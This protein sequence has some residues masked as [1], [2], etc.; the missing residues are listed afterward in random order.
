[1]PSTVDVFVNG[2]R[3]ASEDVPPGPFTID[4][5]PAITG[6][7]QMQV[8]VTDALGRQQVIAQ[9]YYSG[10][11]L[12]RAGPQRVLVRGGRDPRGLRPAQQRLR[13]PGRGR[14]V[15]AR[16]HRP[17]SPPRCTPRRR[18]A[19]QLRPAPTRPGRS[20]N[21][22][23]RERSPPRPAATKTWA[24]SAASASS[25]TATASACSRARPYATE[26]FAQLGTDSLEDRP[27]QRSFGGAGLR[28][29]PLRQPA[30]RLR[31]AEQLDDA[32]QR[33]DRLSHSVHARRLGYLNFIASHSTSD[34]SATDLFLSWTL[35]LGDRRTA[36][37]STAAVARRDRRRGLRGGRHAAAEPAGGQRHRLLR[38][39]VLERGRAA[40]LPCRATPASSACSTRAATARTAGASTRSGGL[41]IT[42]AGV[43]PSRRLDQSFA[44]VEVADFPD[45][46]VF[47]ENQPVGRTDKQGPRAARLAARLRA[48]RR[49]HR[50]HGTADG[51]LAGDAPP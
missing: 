3:V 13:R 15:P 11:T 50:P 17:R 22:R 40:R 10:R 20:G 39:A 33:D 31:P 44:V 28:P 38:V 6:A 12:L 19:A 36:A 8:V 51:R 43:M 41:A 32:E 30:A 9:P 37:V 48:Q 21:A 16:L 5:L 42:G 47:V 45:M 46:T 35:P 25:A 14:H 29:R 1:M 18:P 2:R 49:Q 34:D 4:R 23:H 26:S 24:G 27:R 7:G